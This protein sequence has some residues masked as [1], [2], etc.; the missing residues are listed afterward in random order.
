MG[1]DGDT[2]YKQP[3]RHSWSARAP[4]GGGADC[5]MVVPATA[6]KPAQLSWAFNP[7]QT[8]LDLALNKA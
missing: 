5:W 2:D 3:E 8:D 7:L 6:H 1:S 4:A